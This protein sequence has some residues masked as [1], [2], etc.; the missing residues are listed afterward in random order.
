MTA[1]QFHYRTGA[2]ATEDTPPL[3]AAP[4]DLF[5]AWSRAIDE[6]DR[7]RATAVRLG[8]AP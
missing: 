6:R 1:P 7:A 5:A 4:L 2:V 8:V 3:Q